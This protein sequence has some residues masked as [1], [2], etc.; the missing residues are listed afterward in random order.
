MR[1][2]IRIAMINA[3]GVDPRILAPLSPS[4]GSLMTVLA[5]LEKALD[6]FCF[7]HSFWKQMFDSFPFSLKRIPN[8]LISHW[9]TFV[10][11]A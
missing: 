4:Q 10:I 9:V 8:S 2:F 3:G 1:A 5:L 11:I 7:S 6:R